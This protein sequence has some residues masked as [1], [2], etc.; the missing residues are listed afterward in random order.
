M[1]NNKIIVEICSFKPDAS[2]INAK[3]SLCPKVWNT[4]TSTLFDHVSEKLKKIAQNFID[5]LEFKI[6]VKDIILTGSLANYNWNDLSDIDLH[7][8]IDF[9]E[10]PDNLEETFK[11]YFDSKKNVWN[12]THDINIFGHEV[13]L[14][15]QDINEPHHSSGIYSITNR[16][17]IKK[18]KKL[19]NEDIDYDFITK[20]A[21]EFIDKIEKVKSLYKSGEY[22][23]AIVKGDKLKDKLKSFRKT[24]LSSEGEMSNENLVF[25]SLRNE[26]YIDILHDIKRLSLDKKMSLTEAF[27]KK[28]KVSKTIGFSNKE[29]LDFFNRFSGNTWV[30][31]DT[32]TTGLDPSGAQLTEIAAIAVSAND[33]TQEPSISSVFNVKIA[34]SEETK[35]KIKAEKEKTSQV[36]PKFGQKST[37]DI[38][39]MTRY[40]E[41]RGKFDFIE[42]QD[43]INQFV[44][45]VNSQN[46]AVIVG[47]NVSFDM[48]FVNS[49]SKGKKITKLP[50][51]DTLPLIKHHIIPLLLTIKDDTSGKIPENMQ[52]NAQ[53]ILKTLERKTR[54][55]QIYFSSSLGHVSQALS[56]D[57]AEWHKAI[58]D[59]KML[60]GV[61]SRLYAL[62]NQFSDI[63]TRKERE[64]TIKFNK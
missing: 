10:L 62:L 16:D 33:W 35:Q 24:G 12:E 19:S 37:Q 51:I 5:S 61:F 55:G 44:E 58:A 29:M 54:S 23:K 49:R 46:N 9:D 4:N 39:K 63:D 15:I 18:P 28:S 32:E 11:D 34:L 14:Y 43:A 47:Q 57:S 21:C 59:V 1:K 3:K 38:L 56:M 13:E 20:K 64:K 30:F 8:V 17:W 41:K 6:K 22:E 50:V 31:F 26:G 60:M 27:K 53:N 25:K 36:T 52:K 45:F 42:E 7:I 48:K 40:G 2:R